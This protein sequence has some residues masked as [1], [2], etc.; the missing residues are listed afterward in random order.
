MFK[1]HFI[2]FILECY[3]KHKRCKDQIFR[4]IYRKL[5]NNK[6]RKYEITDFFPYKYVNNCDCPTLTTHTQLQINVIK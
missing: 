2:K 3:I 1:K 5:K 6:E 4:T